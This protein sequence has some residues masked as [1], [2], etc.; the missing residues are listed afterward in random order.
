MSQETVELNLE[1][2]TS[3]VTS[4]CSA[5]RLVARLQPAGGP[6]SKV[7]PPT[8]SEG[9]YAWET[10]LIDGG[11]VVKT[12]LLDSVQSQANRMEQALKEAYQTGQ[13]N[14]PLLAVDFG[15]EFAEIGEIT[16]LDAPHRIADA[17]FRDSLLDGK[18]FPETDI[19][20][21]YAAANQ[22]NATALYQYC[23]H[24]LVF[25]IWDSTGSAGGLG[26]KF[27]RALVS[28]IVGIKAEAGVLT[29]SRLDP[30]GI[31]TVE[32]YATESGGWTTD[33]ALAKT[34]KKGEPVKIKPSEVNHSNIPPTI[35]KS[36]KGDEYIR[37]G[38]TIDYAHQTTVLSLPALRR[39]N[40]PVNG[41]LSAQINIAARTVLAALGLA[42]IVHQLENGYDLRSRCLLIADGKFTF[43][44]VDNYG[45]SRRF[46]LTTDE[47]VA[48]FNAAVANAAKL[49]LAWNTQKVRLQ[50]T[51]DLLELVKKS[52]QTGDL[53]E[54]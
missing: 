46:T 5:I 48:L 21:A 12:V 29:S 36:E 50:P 3:A 34:D 26:N 18:K 54:A 45:E 14:F 8:H 17:I 23:P 6:G 39:L 13:L 47:A 32:I 52:R 49:G 38:V 31:K 53:S 15:G 42:A 44:L 7:F 16:T 2:L 24:A 25:G 28:E 10:R 30:L 11:E 37:G 40:F 20:K 41:E 35:E 33:K 1:T 43:E 4:G 9:K 27:Q 22:R 19:A 51:S